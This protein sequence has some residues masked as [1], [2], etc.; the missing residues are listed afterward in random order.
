MGEEGEQGGHRDGPRSESKDSRLQSRDRE[1]DREPAGY[2]NHHW[3]Q[4]PSSQG[5]E[6]E[7]VYPGVSRDQEREDRARGLWGSG[8]E[9]GNKIPQKEFEQVPRGRGDWTPP[10]LGTAHWSGE[11]LPGR[12]GE[13]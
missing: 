1:T 4:V 13:V 5:V 10:T 6:R 12:G 8:A 3:V 9:L 11:G 2:E 7:Q